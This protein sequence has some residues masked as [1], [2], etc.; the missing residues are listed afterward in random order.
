M[1][2]HRGLGLTTGDYVG[3]GQGWYQ[4][5]VVSDEVSDNSDA[6]AEFF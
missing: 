3:N 4:I 5:I 1:K 2:E 6:G